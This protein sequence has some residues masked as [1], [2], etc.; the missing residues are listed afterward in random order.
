MQITMPAYAVSCCVLSLYPAPCI[1][2]CAASPAEVTQLCNVLRPLISERERRVGFHGAPH[3]LEERDGRCFQRRAQER[4][5]AGNRVRKHKHGATPASSRDG[6]SS[7]VAR[8]PLAI[9]L[10][11]VCHAMPTAAEFTISTPRRSISAVDAEPCIGEAQLA[12]L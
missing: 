8:I 1:R 4:T 7:P 5:L 9:T 6:G 10:P 3:R 11:T 2:V 12:Y